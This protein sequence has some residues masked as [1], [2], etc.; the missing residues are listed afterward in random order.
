LAILTRKAIVRT[1]AEA[2]AE[3]ATAPLLAHL[4][5]TVVKMSSEES[6]VG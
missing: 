3:G 2:Q 4:V 6:A 1:V 5:G